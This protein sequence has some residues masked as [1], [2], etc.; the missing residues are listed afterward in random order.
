MNSRDLFSRAILSVLLG[1]MLAGCTAPRPMPDP[2][3]T[4]WVRQLPTSTHAVS[5]LVISTHAIS[6]LPT[7]TSS[8]RV[9]PSPTSPVSPLSTAAFVSP[10]STPTT[11]ATATFTPSSTPTVPPSPTVTPL[12]VVSTPT[13][14]PSVPTATRAQPVATRALTL[15]PLR[16]RTPAPTQTPAPTIAPI[17]VTAWVSDGNPPPGVD[18]N[19]YGRLLINGKPVAGEGMVAR[20]HM[21]GGRIV[22]CVGDTWLN[23][24]AYCTANTYGLPAGYTIHIEV[25]IRYNQVPYRAATELTIR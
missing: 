20:W 11:P 8:G 25:F 23:G 9:A 6:P 3:S 17:Q 16:T 19:V 10:L 4:I 7:A 14:P 2:T 5:P 15:P 21:K 13:R 18:V 1:A 24:V 12:I 22:D